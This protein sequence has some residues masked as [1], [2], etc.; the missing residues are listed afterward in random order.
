[1]KKKFMTSKILQLISMG[2]LEGPDPLKINALT[3]H[4]LM[5]YLYQSFIHPGCR[6]CNGKAVN[7]GIVSD[8]ELQTLYCL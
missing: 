6:I 8:I 4:S 1:M 7:T 5:L 3:C 2:L